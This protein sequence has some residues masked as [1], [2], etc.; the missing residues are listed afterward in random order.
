[1][2][3]RKRTILFS[4]M[5]AGDPGQGG[6]TWAVLQY[7]LGLRRLGHD[8]YLVEPVKIL[9]DS[10][11]DYFRLVTAEFGL[12]ANAVLIE[13][14][15]RQTVGTSYDK[16]HDVAARADVLINVSGM[17]A[18]P[19]LID[20]IPTR[21][22]LD[23]DPAFVQLWHATQG[24]D[25]RLDAHT[26][27]VTVGQA[28]GRPG[29]TVPTCERSWIGTLPPAVLEHWP[30]GQARTNG[31]FT[32]VANWRGYGS[33]EHDGVRYGQK[34][35]SLRQLIDLP[36]RTREEFLLALSIHPDERS[37]LA[38]LRQNGWRLIDPVEAAGS[39]DRYRRFVQRSLGEFGLAKE[40]YVVSR[41]GWFS[42]RSA[43]YLASGVPV[44]AQDTGFGEFIPTG[45]GLLSFR[46]TEDVLVAMD[47]L[48]S[49]PARHSAAARTLAA[50]WF[51]SDR[52]LTRLLDAVGV[53]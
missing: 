21:V 7:L 44:I 9:G 28:I 30:V 38:A 3:A 27:F 46:T 25:M 10:V 53:T 33:I 42:D 29:C 14:G 20:R 2:P 40:G 13:A 1:M 37:D 5:L 22:Y 36:T 17:L 39:P 51:D 49:D 50:E 48:R 12:D 18:D 34:A 19:A 23:L 24:V 4:G 31:A 41:C 47:R 15:S 26:H 45:E 16:L 32:T 6:A 43:C 52:V 11:I 8:V 35:H